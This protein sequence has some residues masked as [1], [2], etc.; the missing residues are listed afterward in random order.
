LEMLKNRSVRIK[1]LILLAVLLASTGTVGAYTALQGQTV[2]LEVKEPLEVLPFDS[3]LSL[4]PGETLQ[5]SVA[6]ENHASVSYNASLIFG[7]N[8]TAYQQNYVNFSSNTYL[9]LPGANSLDA[10]LSVVNTAPAAELELTVNVTRDIAALPTPTPT[11]TPTATNLDPSMALFAAGAKW[12]ANNGTS[13]LYVDWYDNYCAHHLSDPSWGPWWREG[14]LAEIK[15]ATVNV[16]EQQGFKVTCAGDVPNDLSGYNLV[17]YEAWFAVEP[18]HVTLVRDYLSNGGNIVITG[19]AP[20]YFATYCRDM[21][22]YVTGGTNLASLSDWFGSAQF[23]N[24]GGTANLVVDKPL[25][26]SLENHSPIY[27]IDAYGCYA[28]TSMSQDTQII[29]QWAD[30]SVY[31]FTHEYGKGRVFYQAEMVW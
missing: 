10:W 25:G 13:A 9:I 23:V 2:P 20:C 19:G 18:K 30:G 26:T 17:I 5:F 28:L 14:Q 1:A 6:V 22:P 4:Y 12:A 7:L 27:H 8:D 29:A 3:S 21:W 11:P 16:L 24:T 31:A 15:N